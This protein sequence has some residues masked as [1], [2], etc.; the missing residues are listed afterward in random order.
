MN[1]NT[2]SEHVTKSEEQTALVDGKGNAIAGTE[3]CIL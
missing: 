2:V 3:G 1:K